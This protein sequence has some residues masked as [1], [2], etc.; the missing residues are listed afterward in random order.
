M[1]CHL[2]AHAWLYTHSQTIPDS[3]VLFDFNYTLYK[4]KH[5]TWFLYLVLC[6][7]QNSL[8]G[9]LSSGLDNLL[10]VVVL[11]LKDKTS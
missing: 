3:V 10:D 1:C 7:S 11:G 6:V 2:V 9:S 8:H 4:I 5:Y